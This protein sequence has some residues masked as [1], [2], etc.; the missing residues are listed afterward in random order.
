MADLVQDL[1]YE[2]PGRYRP[3]E[4]SRPPAELLKR[5]GEEGAED[6]AKPEGGAPAEGTP[7]GKA[8]AKAPVKGG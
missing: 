4:D 7:E 5:L 3:Q 6:D 1:G 8:P 2:L